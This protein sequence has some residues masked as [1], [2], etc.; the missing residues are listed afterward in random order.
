MWLE[1]GGLE[2]GG[3]AEGR[4]RMWKLWLWS[5]RSGPTWAAPAFRASLTRPRE[6]HFCHAFVT[7]S[8]PARVGGV[9]RTP[10]PFR[11]Q[12]SGRKLLV[13]HLALLLQDDRGHLTGRL[14]DGFQSQL[15]GTKACAAGRGWSVCNPDIET[16]LLSHGFSLFFLHD[17]SASCSPSVTDTQPSAP[18]S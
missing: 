11:P 10:D 15:W 14:P 8:G 3:V 17:V 5:K 1:G 2:Q 4:T 16:R 13:I 9:C 12:P 7:S 6:R 18:I